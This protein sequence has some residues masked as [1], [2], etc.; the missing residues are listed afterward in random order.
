MPEREVDFL[1]QDFIIYYILDITVRAHTIF[2]DG[3]C[4]TREAAQVRLN[5]NIFLRDARYTLRAHVQT[6]LH[7]R[8]LCLLDRK[9][10]RERDAMAE[11]GKDIKINTA[12]KAAYYTGDELRWEIPAIIN[13]IDIHLG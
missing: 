1:F 10:D 13:M 7:F 4:L 9:R 6:D 5:F 3:A 11:R 12:Y 2:T 8:A